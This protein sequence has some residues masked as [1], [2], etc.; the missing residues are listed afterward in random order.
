MRSSPAG[1][2]VRTVIPLAGRTTPLIYI[3]PATKP[4][5]GPESDSSNCQP[6]VRVGP[7]WPCWPLSLLVFLVE[8]LYLPPTSEESQILPTEVT[9]LELYFVL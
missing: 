2:A 5:R 7:C 9:A 8:F 6:Q 1:H 3:A 4:M